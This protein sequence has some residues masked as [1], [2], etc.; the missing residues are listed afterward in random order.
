[1]GRLQAVLLGGELQAEEGG[2][3]MATAGPLW[4]EPRPGESTD[5]TWLALPLF[6]AP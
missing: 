4:C 3:G 2:T 5:S 6:A 1:M